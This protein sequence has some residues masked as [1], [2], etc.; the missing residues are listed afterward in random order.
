[1]PDDPTLEDDVN[2]ALTRYKASGDPLAL[3][4]TVEHLGPTINGFIGVNGLGHSPLIQNQAKLLAA[5]AIQSYDPQH[6]ASIST[7]VTQ[8]LRPLFRFRQQKLRPI[9]PTERLQSDAVTLQSKTAEFFEDRGR[10][11][12]ILELADHAGM[13]VKRIKQ[14][15]GGGHSVG[16]EAR[17]IDAFGNDK[18]LHSPIV[19]DTPDYMTDAVNILL[20]DLG[21]LD[22]RIL[23]MKTGFAGGETLTHAEIASRLKLSPATLTRRAA[24]LKLKL[25]EIHA[26]LSEP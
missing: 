2:S 21:T 23:E 8:G 6:G 11:P 4:Q 14:I 25:N 9:A 3:H 24:R 12:D 13:S 7:W 22:R 10:E 5:K 20:P 18:P 19:D 26:A 17:A 1:M 15:R 16:T